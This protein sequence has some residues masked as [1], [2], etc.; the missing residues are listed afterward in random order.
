VRLFGM[1]LLIGLIATGMFFR[2]I[3]PLIVALIVLFTGVV[4]GG[5]EKELSPA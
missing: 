2:L 4:R 5:L 3:L 1:A